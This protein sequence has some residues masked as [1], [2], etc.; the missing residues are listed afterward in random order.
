MGWLRDIV[1][2]NILL[3]SKFILRTF[4]K[5][6]SF[7]LTDSSRM[8]FFYA[9]NP[10]MV[11]DEIKSSSVAPSAFSYSTNELSRSCL[12]RRFYACGICRACATLD[13]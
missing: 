11:V 7:D 1:E 6:K 2:L 3:F 12:F 5:I 4:C 13:R 8:A 10:V 9:R